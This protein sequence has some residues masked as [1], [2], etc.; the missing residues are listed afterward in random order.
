MKKSLLLLFNAAIAAALM[1]SC[2]T[3]ADKNVCM[4]ADTLKNVD[5]VAA[6]PPAFNN[7]SIIKVIDA[8]RERIET[9]LEKF[10]KNTLQTKDMREQVKQKWSKLDYYSEN[11][12][13]VRIKSYPYKQISER[14]EEFY[15]CNGALILAFIEDHGASNKGKSD[16]R[17]GKTFYFHNDTIIKEINDTDEPADTDEGIKLLKEAHE[18]LAIQ[19][20][21]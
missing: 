14:T 1:V 5:S 18:Y 2:N 3:G 12:Q 13:V 16:Q 9:G 19:A 8:E 6:A 7:D 21:K 10:Q 15:F 17:K 4:G 11:N 20:G